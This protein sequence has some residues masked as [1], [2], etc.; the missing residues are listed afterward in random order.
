MTSTSGTKLFNLSWDEIL[1]EAYDRVGGEHITGRDALTARRSMNLLLIDLMN[2]EIPIAALEER[3]VTVQ[4]SVAE[5]TLSADVM[6]VMYAVLARS[7]VE[8]VMDKKSLF[9]FKALPKKDQ[10]GR[11][12]LYTTH[13]D[14]SAVTLKLWP[15]PENN[16]DIF[17]YWAVVRIDDI[18]RQ[19]QYVELPVRALPMIVSGLAYYIALKRIPDNMQKVAMLKS[20][21]EETMKRFTDADRER[22]SLFVI[23]GLARI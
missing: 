21:F 12:T 13:E 16:T 15:M 17:K 22:S 18:T 14:T 8:I 19:D 1:E 5:Y 6:T 9:D 23:P 3:E 20:E 7:S 2:R 10:T 4:S 11:P